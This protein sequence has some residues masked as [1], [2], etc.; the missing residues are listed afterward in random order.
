MPM[1]LGDLL[2]Q[3]G[4]IDDEQRAEVLRQQ[5][6][7]GRPFGLL[8]EEMFGVDPRAVER[9]W[10]AQYAGYAERI[11]LDTETPSVDA[12]RV[13][14]PRQAW[15]FAVLPLRIEQDELVLATTEEHLARALRFAG[16]RVP[17]Q[18]RFAI[19]DE[20]DLSRA[21][22]QHYPMAG[23]TTD[24]MRSLRLVMDG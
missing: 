9:A 16:W 10:A 5:R 2:V 6:V 13:L 24:A 23:L 18:C 4:V 11:D 3:R 1:R 22:E 8:A 17:F 7:T 14:E 19:C 12:L 20:Q 15:Q 21:I